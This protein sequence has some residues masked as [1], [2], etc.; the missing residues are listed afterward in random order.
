[1]TPEFL[2]Y[3]GRGWG[4]VPWAHEDVTETEVNREL[5]RNRTHPI[6]V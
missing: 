2:E 1:M 4:H 5:P 6:R 3:S